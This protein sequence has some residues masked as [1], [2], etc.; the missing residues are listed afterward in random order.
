MEII[1]VVWEAQT[2]SP[3]PSFTD[4]AAGAGQPVVG[5]RLMLSGWMASYVGAAGG[6]V[7][8][9]LP[10]QPGFRVLGMINCHQLGLFPWGCLEMDQFHQW[11]GRAR[12]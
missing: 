7:K 10:A 6:G 8:L 12:G 2:L 5:S 11:V 4:R 3:Q 1:V 9:A